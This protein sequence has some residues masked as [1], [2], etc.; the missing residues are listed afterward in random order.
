MGKITCFG[1]ASMVLDE[2]TD[3]NKGNYVEVP[4]GREYIAELCAGFDE[5]CAKFEAKSF[6]VDVD[7]TTMNVIMEVECEDLEAKIGDGL[8]GLTA[9]AQTFSIKVSDEDKE[10]VKIRFVFDGI[11]RKDE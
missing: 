5:L 8:F 2:V 3:R 10:C 6:S 7:E 11:W 9:A 1:V 4:R